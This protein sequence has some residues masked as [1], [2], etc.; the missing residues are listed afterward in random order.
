MVL[1]GQVLIRD[2]LN[3][4]LIYKEKEFMFNGI[5]QLNCNGLLW[6]NSLNVD[7]IKIGYIDKVGYN[8]VVFVIEGQMCLIFVV[9]GG[10]I[11]KGC[12]VESKKLLIWGF[13]F[14]EIVNL[15]KVGKE[16]VFE[17]VWFGDFDCVLLGV[18]KDVYLIISCGC[19][20]DLKVSYVLNSSELYVLL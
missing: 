15:L 7:G 18:D 1:I 14:F 20:K 16:F 4:Y 12:E 11:F 13:C 17:L 10:C 2:V 3:E 19:M 5:R 8:F 6:D 9:M